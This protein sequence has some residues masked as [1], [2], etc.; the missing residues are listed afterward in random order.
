MQKTPPATPLSARQAAAVDLL[1]WVRNGR[2][3]YRQRDALSSRQEYAL[4]R[5][6]VSSS[7]RHRDACFYLIEKLTRRSL[8][9]LDR[10]AIVCL[11]LG[12]TQLQ[13]LTGVQP[14]AAV[15]ET[16]E[17]AGFL[18][19]PHLKGFINANLRTFQRSR[20]DLIASLEQQALAI[21]SSHPAWM[22][23]RWRD[24]YGCAAAEQLCLDNNRPPQVRIV[25][26]PAFDRDQVETELRA[27]H[28][29]ITSGGGLT[30]TDPAGLFDSEWSASG[31][32]LVQDRSSQLINTLVRPLIKKTVLDACAAPGGKLFHLEWEFGPEIDT[33][34]ALDISEKRL[35]RFKINQ[36]RYRSRAAT[37][38]MNA[39]EP[40]LS[41]P[42]DLVLLD[43]PCSATG[44]IQKHPEL[45]WQRDPDAF[46]VNQRRQLSIL[47]GLRSLVKKNGHLLYISCS[48]EKEEN[49]DVIKQFLSDDNSGFKPVPFAADGEVEPYITQEGYFQ[50]LPGATAMGLFAA[51][52]RRTGPE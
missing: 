1:E 46:L 27:S 31:G 21:R 20:A 29:I 6:L 13:H 36:E 38:C 45:K 3:R 34:V 24:Q 18:K 22:V 4:Y 9:K 23:D 5:S 25:I 15:N 48:L 37:V 42:F 41:K 28:E 14:H 50:L 40:G 52:L 51:L 8:Q 33:L 19:K 10:E 44:T 11:M 26:N 30:V 32:F 12:L 49:Q 35:R 16:V 39:A 2:I 47:S 17:L 43:A 7:I